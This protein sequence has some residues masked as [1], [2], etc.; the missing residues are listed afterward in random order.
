M[1]TGVLGMVS[2]RDPFGIRPL[3]FGSK[4]EGVGQT[5]WLHRVSRSGFREYEVER[6]V[7]PGEAVFFDTHNACSKQCSDNATLTPCIFEHVSCR[8]DSII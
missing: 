7:A 1:I 4:N 2:F 6:D 8:P 5:L 3:I